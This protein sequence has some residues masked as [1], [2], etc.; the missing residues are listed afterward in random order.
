[1][2]MEKGTGMREKCIK[3]Q[4]TVPETSSVAVHAEQVWL[5][6]IHYFLFTGKRRTGTRTPDTDRGA[7]TGEYLYITQVEPA[8]AMSMT[9]FPAQDVWK[10]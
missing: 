10:W 1:M 5:Y 3:K 9:I 4:S 7:G 6:F 2:C 8:M